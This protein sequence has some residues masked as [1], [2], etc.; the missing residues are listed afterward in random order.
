[1]IGSGQSN[2]GLCSPPRGLALFA[3]AVSLGLWIILVGAPLLAMALRV[4]ASAFWDSTVLSV[5]KSTAQQALI[6]TLLSVLLGLP[7]G[8]AVGGRL[9]PSS[10]AARWV[11]VM[12]AVP[13]SIPTVVSATTGLLW[14]GRNGIFAKFGWPLDWAYSFSGII[15]MHVLYNLPWVALLVAQARWAVPRRQIEAACTL[16][17]STAQRFRWVIW[18]YVRWALGA[19]AVQVFSL[20]VLSF[21]L[22]LLMG[23]G[24]PVQTLETLIYSRIRLSG[25]DLT[26]AGAAAVAQLVLTCV[27]WGF[28]LALRAR[29][30]VRLQAEVRSDSLG[31]EPR[32]RTSPSALL[33]L[34]LCALPLVPYV[35]FLAQVKWGG[36][37]TSEMMEALRAPLAVSLLLAL[38]AAG[39]SVFWA[40]AGILAGRR[41]R[42]LEPA[43]RMLMSVPAGIS[44]LV[45]GL[46]TWLVLGRWVD[47]FEGSI[48][49]M[50]GLQATVFLPLALRVL[51]PVADQAQI[52]QLEAARS[53]GAGPIAAFR[54]VEWPRWKPALKI[55]LGLVAG[56]SLG[57][58]AAV[59]LFYSENLIP[60]PLVVARL[61]AQYRF[62]EA[63]AVAALLM[64]VSTGLLV[65]V[66]ERKS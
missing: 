36:V 62:E 53:L 34:G 32:R 65:G 60:L 19:A 45:L 20:C 51:T 29:D 31:L 15:A 30:P 46:G 37:L 17:A 39:L 49:A 12:L 10:G 1:M 63:H 55:A 21:G 26:G 18:P 22:V 4:Q 8:L 25:L 56:A 13:F 23:G 54:W 58:V 61:T 47:P 64:L 14:M 43:L 27:P 2:K 6:S 24:P 28:L 35:V 57:E 42:V 52:A 40:C 41:F 9:R 44:V 50:I 48:W 11:R 16:G 38:G 3:L 59:S 33:L 7:L 66:L 5:A